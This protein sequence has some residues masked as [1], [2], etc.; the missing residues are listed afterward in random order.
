MIVSVG[1]NVIEEQNSGC[2]FSFANIME[3]LIWMVDW[4]N[5]NNSYLW[6]WYDVIS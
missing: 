1:T 3:S 5:S 6:I 4:L 2:L